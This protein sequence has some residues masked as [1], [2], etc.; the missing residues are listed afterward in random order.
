[1]GVQI[2]GCKI[3]GIFENVSICNN[4]HVADIFKDWKEKF[5]LWG[6]NSPGGVKIL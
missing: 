1:M 6:K 5:F 3:F 4:Y 2:Q